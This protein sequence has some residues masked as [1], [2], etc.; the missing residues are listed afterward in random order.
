MPGMDAALCRLAGRLVRV[1]AR[2]VG[3]DP[4][5]QREEAEHRDEDPEQDRDD[6]GGRVRRLAASGVSS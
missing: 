5:Q 2:V 3:V 6:G 4:H 1:V